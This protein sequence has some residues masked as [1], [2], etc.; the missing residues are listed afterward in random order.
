MKIATQFFMCLLL[1]IDL[2]ISGNLPEVRAQSETRRPATLRAPIVE[3]NPAPFVEPLL[4]SISIKRERNFSFGHVIQSTLPGICIM[5]PDGSRSASGA[6]SLKETADDYPGQF[7]VKGEPNAAFLIS[8]PSTITIEM[9]GGGGG[10]GGGGPTVM[11]VDNFTTSVGLSSTIG[12]NG[13]RTFTVGGTL[14]IQG[15][16]EIGEYAGEFSV[17]VCYD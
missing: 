17:T 9:H 16:Q 12:S 13:I 7:T 11:D 1:T 8:F 5:N 3:P 2:P 15:S 4:V 10:G 6:V 14:H